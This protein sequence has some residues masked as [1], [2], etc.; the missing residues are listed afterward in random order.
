MIYQFGQPMLKEGLKTYF[1]KYSHKNTELKDFVAE[2]ATAA[3]TVGAVSDESIM[4]NWAESWLKTAGCAKIDLIHNSEG[5]KL[6]SVQVKQTPFN[7]KNTPENK[8]RV[9]KF[10]IALFDKDMKVIKEVTHLTSDK[11]EVTEVS[12]LKGVDT[13]FA[14][15]INYKAHGYGKFIIDEMT[16]TAL[17]SSL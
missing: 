13:P 16:L 12:E 11:D 15:A 17:E 14:F 10:I 9:Q 5:G 4:L 1:A 6:T 7:K 2:L 8:L 3:K